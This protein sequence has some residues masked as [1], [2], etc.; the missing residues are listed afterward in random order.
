VWEIQGKDVTDDR[1]RSFANP[2]TAASATRTRGH[3]RAAAVV[4]A[5]AAAIVELVTVDE[6]RIWNFATFV[7]AAPSGSPFLILGL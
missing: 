4:V 3:S 1:T 6:I 5:V 2:R 7:A